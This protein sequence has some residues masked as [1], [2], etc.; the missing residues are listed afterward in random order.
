VVVVVIA[1]E[2]SG[3]VVIVIEEVNYR[4]TIKGLQ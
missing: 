4:I 1:N 2:I 3:E